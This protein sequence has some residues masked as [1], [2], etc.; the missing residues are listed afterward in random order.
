MGGLGSVVVC[1]L[2]GMW[3]VRVRGG[4]PA[5]GWFWFMCRGCGI[6]GEVWVVVV[7]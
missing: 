1:L 6:C 3:V 4:M 7:R 5:Q 2:W